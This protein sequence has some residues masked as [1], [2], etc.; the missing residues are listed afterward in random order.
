MVEERKRADGA[1]VS[2][3]AANRA[4]WQR[5]RG[6]GSQLWGQVTQLAARGRWRRTAAAAER[7]R[8]RGAQ[9]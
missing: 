5:L 3:G 1:A 8:G 4:R 7:E 6:A 9:G 2:G